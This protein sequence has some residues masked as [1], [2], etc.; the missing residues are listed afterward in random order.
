MQNSCF[1]KSA[2]L[3]LCR[4]I[5]FKT[6][7]YFLHRRCYSKGTLISKGHI[8]FYYMKYSTETPSIC[9]CVC[10]KMF[11]T[12]VLQSDSSFLLRKS[13]K[14]NTTS[15]EIIEIQL[16]ACNLHRKFALFCKPY[17]LRHSIEIFS[18]YSLLLDDTVLV[19]K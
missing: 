13:M 9:I 4:V 17:Y 15:S 2:K 5:S 8:F 1:Y 16:Y 19:W 18:D 10:V 6:C 7:W 14:T 3:R 11:L 12:A